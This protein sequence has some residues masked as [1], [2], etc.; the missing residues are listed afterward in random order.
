MPYA[1]AARQLGIWGISAVAWAG[2][3]PPGTVGEGPW[4]G[5]GPAGARRGHHAGQPERVADVL[6]GT[7]GRQSANDAIKIWGRSAPLTRAAIRPNP[8]GWSGSTSAATSATQSLGAA[9][10]DGTNTASPA[11]DVGGVPASS[12]HDASWKR[13]VRWPG[14]RGRREARV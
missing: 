10:N 13:H 12:D 8:P 6:P 11:S 3:R 14:V 5:S 7:V 1:A 2:S 4:P 9:C